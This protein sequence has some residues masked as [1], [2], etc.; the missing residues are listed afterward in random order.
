MVIKLD[1]TQIFT[2]QPRLLLCNLFAVANL[3]VKML[4]QQR[5]Y[6]EIIIKD[7]YPYLP[8]TPQMPV[9]SKVDDFVTF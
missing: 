4:S 7:D 6:N 5:M 2:D 9:F 1:V 3:V 8:I